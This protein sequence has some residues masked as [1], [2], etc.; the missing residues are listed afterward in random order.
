MN[1]HRATTSETIEVAGNPMFFPQ[2]FDSLIFGG[3]FHVNMFEHLQN[4]ETLD[5]QKP[6]FFMVF[7][8]NGIDF[9]LDGK[10]VTSTNLP[11]GQRDGR[12]PSWHSVF[13]R[14]SPGNLVLSDRDPHETIGLT[15]N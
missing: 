10:I 4:G 9:F 13:Q 7:P 5:S 3:F 15:K 8:I 14:W 12:P 6:R 2:M 11:W 1:G